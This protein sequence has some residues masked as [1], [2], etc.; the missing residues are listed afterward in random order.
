MT[1]W[2]KS[3]PYYSSPFL[4]V[5]QV[6]PAYSYPQMLAGDC[7][8]YV[9]AA[10]SRI[11]WEKDRKR[12]FDIGEWNVIV[13]LAT[14]PSDN[15]RA[16]LGDTGN[17]GRVRHFLGCVMRAYLAH[18]RPWWRHP[19]WHVRHFKFQVHFVQA[20]KR[21]RWSRC[22]LCGLRFK[23]G[24]SPVSHQWHGTG[25]LWFKSEEKIYHQR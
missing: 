2:D 17:L 11:A 6:D 21:W 20:F 22:A 16:I 12:D 5:T 1:D 7:L 23:W 25:P 15:L 3:F 19:R 18:C 13:N 24:E 10:W 4:P 9:A 8:A 14:N